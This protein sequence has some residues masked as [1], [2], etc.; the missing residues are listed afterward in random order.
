MPSHR[1]PALPV[2]D[3]EDEEGIVEGASSS[4]EQEEMEEEETSIHD[5]QLPM[6]VLPLY[7]LLSPSQQKKVSITGNA[8]NL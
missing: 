5:S 2:L 6:R 4:S 8:K 3:D 7:S 1:S